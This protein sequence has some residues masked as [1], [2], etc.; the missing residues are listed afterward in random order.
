MTWT[1]INHEIDK[2]PWKPNREYRVKVRI[3][4]KDTT[5]YAHRVDSFLIYVFESYEGHNSPVHERVVMADTK[6]KLVTRQGDGTSYDVVALHYR[7]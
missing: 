1:K 6:Q 4:G 3:G 5:F 2:K 7:Q